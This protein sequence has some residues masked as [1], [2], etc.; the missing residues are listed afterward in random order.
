MTDNVDIAKA[1]AAGYSRAANG[2]KNLLQQLAEQCGQDSIKYFPDIQSAKGTTYGRLLHDAGACASE[3]GE[4]LEVVKKI[5]RGSF[6]YDNEGT[7]AALTGEAVDVLIYVLNVFYDL[8]V[9]PLTAYFKKRDFNN[10]R[11]T[12]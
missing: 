9:D 6:E 10:G 3:A 1:F 5:D 4:L 8:G 2:N 7:K 11:F 12:K